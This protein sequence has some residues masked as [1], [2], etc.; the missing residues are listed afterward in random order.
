MTF[1]WHQPK[2]PSD[3]MSEKE[4]EEV[5]GSVKEASGTTAGERSGESTDYSTKGNTSAS[6]TSPSSTGS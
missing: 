1:N 4:S 6:D 3:T 2:P 5:G